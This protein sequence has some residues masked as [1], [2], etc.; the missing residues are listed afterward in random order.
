MLPQ[1]AIKVK[2]RK[3]KN[4]VY[5]DLK[6]YTE[7]QLRS[8]RYNENK[9]NYIIECPYCQD[10]HLHDKS[11]DGPYTKHKLYVYKDFHS[12]HCFRCNQVFVNNDESL[13][14]DIPYHDDVLKLTDF[15]L[16][17]LSKPPWNLEL[18]ESFDEYDEQGYQYLI[19]KRHKYFKD[20]YKILKIRFTKSNPVIPFYYK[21][22]LIYYQIKL[23]FGDSKI[24]Y[25]SPPI[26]AKP[27]YIIG[28]G[29]N[30][31]F[32]VCEGT[33]D[34]IACLILYPDRTPFAVLGSS[35]TD[36]QLAMLR[37]Y[38]PEDILVYMD[39]TELSIGVTNKIR[40]YINYAEVNIQ[41]S[42]GTDPEEFLKMKLLQG[43]E[44]L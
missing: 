1:D 10:A 43:I 41:G 30:K 35:I 29:R 19:K 32:V 4:N 22:E 33:F 18:F 24:P 40:Q 11:Y 16:I 28:H 25:F 38:V 27:A 13:N 34:A 8:G 20:L 9:V 2:T 3:G 14:F 5:M 12:G 26:E 7:E 23:A 36:Y 6:S 15:K 21:G 37:S 44:L 17:K 39:N 31:K 42:D